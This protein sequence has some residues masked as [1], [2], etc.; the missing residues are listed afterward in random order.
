M[1]ILAKNIRD[2]QVNGHRTVKLEITYHKTLLTWL[3]FVIC[4]AVFRH[5]N[6][7][8]TFV[9]YFLLLAL[10]P[11]QT[12]S[13]L[14]CPGLTNSR[15]F[16]T[17]RS[18]SRYRGSFAPKD[19][20]IPAWSPYYCEKMMSLT[21]CHKFLMK[22]SIISIAGVHTVK[23]LLPFTEMRLLNHRDLDWTSSLQRYIWDWE[24]FVACVNLFLHSLVWYMSV[25][26]W[27]CAKCWRRCS[28]LVKICSQNDKI[29]SKSSRN[30]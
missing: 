24:Q 13:L 7:L 28:I 27:D 21:D 18:L 6:M 16:F 4:S 5:V 12:I 14:S 15:L 11:F 19:S 30:C 10:S 9:F 1:Q 17:S 29:G 20:P 22:W 8:S 2:I 25:S 26:I 23:H 3:S